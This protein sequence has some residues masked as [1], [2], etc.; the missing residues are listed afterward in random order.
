M[1]VFAT[2]GLQVRAVAQAPLGPSPSAVPPV[3]PAATTQRLDLSMAVSSG[4][5]LMLTNDTRPGLLVDPRLAFDAG[6]SS[7][8]TTL[9]YS[10]RS[11]NVDFGAS[12]GGNL[13]HYTSIPR[14]LPVNAYGGASSGVRLGER[15]QLRLSGGGSY[16]P[17]YSFGDFLTP[18]AETIAA[19]RADMNVARLDTYTGTASVSFSST[20]TRRMSI[21][22]G[23]NADLVST[24]RSAYR[25]FTTGAHAGTG[26]QATRY[27]NVRFGYGYRRSL[28]GIDTIAFEIHNL[29]AGLGYRRPL[30]FSRRT[31]IAANSGTALV[32]YAGG[33]SFAV[34]GNAS[35]THQLSQRTALSLSYYRDIS[36]FAGITRPF[37]ADSISSSLS[38][39]LTRNLGYSINGGYSL[40]R[41]M[42]DLDNGFSLAS[43]SASLRYRLTR[44]MPLFAEYSYYNYRFERPQGLEDGFPLLAQRHGVRLGVAYSWPVIGRRTP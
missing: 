1:V 8:T 13:Q 38:G 34:I 19:P 37:T 18:R 22:A 9:A 43:G 29:D 24:G 27:S 33:H 30:S 44:F 11:R 10:R 14:L 20:L 28:N 40:G 42:I 39:V 36:M 7:V 41:A 31:I 17:Y 5:D 16:S 4:Y 6:S 26:Y 15:T 32:T 3:R 25:M 12:G 2:L 21:N 35:M 23:T